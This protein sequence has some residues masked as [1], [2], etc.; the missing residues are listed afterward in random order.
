VEPGGGRGFPDVAA[1]KVH[2]HGT[3]TAVSE[4]ARIM[5]AC[6]GLSITTEHHG[7]RAVLRLRGE[8]DVSTADCLREAISGALEKRP[9]TLVLDLSALAFA[10]CTSLSVLVWAHKQLAGRGHQLIVSAPQPIVSRL[11]HL[12]GL[13]K[14]LNVS[15]VSAP[16]AASARCPPPP[17]GPHGDSPQ[18]RQ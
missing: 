9:R 1:P 12:A 7:R 11:L 8:L 6:P 16:G 5:T 10:D 4:A 17:R 18:P 13:D 2:P 15:R 14:Y 3:A